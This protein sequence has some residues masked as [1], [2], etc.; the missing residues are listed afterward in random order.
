MLF[1]K[2]QQENDLLPKTRTLRS[3]DLIFFLLH[4]SLRIFYCRK[5]VVRKRDKILKLDFKQF[6]FFFSALLAL[7]L[8]C[9]MQRPGVSGDK[10]S[11]YVRDKKKFP[12]EEFSYSQK[13]AI[14]KV[15]SRRVISVQQD[16]K[17]KASCKMLLMTFCIHVSFE[18]FPKCLMMSMFR[19][20]TIAPNDSKEE[21]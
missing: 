10:H 9:I 5:I 19:Y 16:T 18:T 6:N 3:V 13:M 7:Q 8:N 21:A 11:S 20:T 12:R 2:K 4:T 1:L 14:F 15:R 17:E